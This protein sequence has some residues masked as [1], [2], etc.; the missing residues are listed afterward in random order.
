[1]SHKMVD[2]YICLKKTSDLAIEES[3]YCG[4]F[5]IGQRKMG[6]GDLKFEVCDILESNIK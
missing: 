5:E 6:C 2:L 3:Q 4:K 1:M